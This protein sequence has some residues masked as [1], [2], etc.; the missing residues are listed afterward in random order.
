MNAYELT[1]IKD[2]DPATRYATRSMTFVGFG[3][4]GAL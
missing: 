1:G 4:L 3:Y 2:M